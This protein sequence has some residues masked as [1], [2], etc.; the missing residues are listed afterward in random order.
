LFF[1]LAECTKTQSRK[2]TILKTVTI[3]RVIANTGLT[4]GPQETPIRTT[5]AELAGLLKVG[6]TLRKLTLS[7]ISSISTKAV[8]NGLATRCSTGSAQARP[9]YSVAHTL[10]IWGS[11]W[12]WLGYV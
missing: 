2:R 4:S 7:G 12:G 10:G 5:G 8:L 6:A 11:G 9:V 1:I 3:S